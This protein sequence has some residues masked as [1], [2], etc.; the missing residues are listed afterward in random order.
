VSWFLR[1]SFKFGP[2]RF[3]ISR[4]GIGTSI[5]VRGLRVGQDA[6]GRRYLFAAKSPLYLRQQIGR[7]TDQPPIRLLT[8][9]V[10]LAA[11]IVAVLLLVR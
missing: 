11:V 2:I 1:K 3:N 5:G 6:R 8:A 4:S 10:V 9:L 7:A